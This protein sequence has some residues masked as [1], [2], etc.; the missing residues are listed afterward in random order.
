MKGI[1][2]VV[3]KEG[4]SRNIWIVKVVESFSLLA[5]QALS[6]AQTTDQGFSDLSE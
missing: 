6:A 3:S 5:G 2:N 4:L 1:D